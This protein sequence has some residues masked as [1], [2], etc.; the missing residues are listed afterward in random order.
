[1]NQN[2]LIVAYGGGVNSTAMLV[3]M[4]SHRIIPELILFADTGGE[5]PETY[6]TVAAVSAWCA[7][8]EFPPI[9]T[10]RATGKSLEQDCLDRKALPSI[11]YG[12]K[13]CSQRWKLQPQQKFI[14]GW[15][16]HGE[17]YTKAIGF[18]AGEER[19]VRESDDSD[20]ANWYPLI[21]W[22]IHRDDCENICLAEGLPTSKS[23]CFFCPSM[24][25]REV[26]DLESKHP[27]LL[28]RALEMEQNADLNTISGLGRHWSW[29]DFVRQEALQKKWDF[30]SATPE[31]ACGCYDG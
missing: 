6:A 3:K 25:R 9:T 30:D 23:S 1:M 15:K 12:F 8:R 5:R 16:I 31:I 24:R 11:A 26:L 20:C 19:R 27:Q 28:K 10:V 21:E 13:T 18:D 29:T 17:K 7:R 4:V 22:G 2:R 14:N